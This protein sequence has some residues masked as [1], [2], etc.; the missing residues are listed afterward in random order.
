MVASALLDVCRFNPTLGGTTDWTYSSAV[1]GYQSPA[2]AG[3]ISGAQYSYRA[4]NAALTEWEIGRGTYSAGVLTRT[5]VLFNSLGTTA[6]ISFTVAPQVSIVLLAEDLQPN[7][8]V[9]INGDFRINQRAYVSAAAL[10]AGIYGH[11]RWKGGASGGTYSFVGIGQT[12]TIAASKTLIQVVEDK[13]VAGGTYVLSWTGTALGRV[14]VNTATPAGTFVASPIILTSQL[15]LTTMS[16]EFGNGASAGTLS[17]VKL[18]QGWM[19]TPFQQA[20]YADELNRCQR[21]FQIIN[22]VTAIGYANGFYAITLPFPGTMRVAPTPTLSGFV[23]NTNSS[24]ATVDTISATGCRF[25][26]SVATLGNF[27]FNGGTIML[28]AEL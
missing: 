1:T 23:Y 12:V 13:N 19:P 22:P 21:Y 8:N 25:F 27:D 26:V 7:A 9:L 5:T 24:G 14:G 28:A 4:E 2:A 15:A 16:V 3:V 20:P 18:E 6:K 10:A 17:N 11:D